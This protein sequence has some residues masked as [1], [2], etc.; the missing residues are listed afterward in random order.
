MTLQ[1]NE[2]FAGTEVIEESKENRLVASSM[3]PNPWRRETQA[4]PSF[5]WS[6]H[7][8]NFHGALDGQRF[9]V[10]DLTL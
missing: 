1:A 5:S 7:W 6:F 3:A 2:T 9:I 10:S 4:F 8:P